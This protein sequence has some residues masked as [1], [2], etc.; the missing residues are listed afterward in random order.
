M[1]KV[2]IFLKAYLS[3]IVEISEEELEHFEE[4]G[5]VSPE[6]EHR[7]IQAIREKPEWEIYDIY[8]VDKEDDLDLI[9]D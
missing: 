9:D 5:R 8:S 4:T 3:Q 2:E 1:P 6:L 7:V